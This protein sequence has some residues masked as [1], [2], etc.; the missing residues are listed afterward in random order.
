MWLIS[1]KPLNGIEG[2]CFNYAWDVFGVVRLSDQ[3]Q[4]VDTMVLAH[5]MVLEPIGCR[6]HIKALSS[7]D[8]RLFCMPNDIFLL[9][10]EYY[11]EF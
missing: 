2:R 9:D 4:V 1:L 5:D 7:H 3:H 8:T 10:G 6:H 11:F